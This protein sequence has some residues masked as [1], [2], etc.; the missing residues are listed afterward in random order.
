MSMMDGA[1]GAAGG[2][3]T[4]MRGGPQ[5]ITTE[6]GKLTWRQIAEYYGVPLVRIVER[7]E[8]LSS[9][10]KAQILERPNRTVRGG[11]QLTVPNVRDD[12]GQRRPR[13]NV[14]KAE[15]WIERANRPETADA[16]AE[17]EEEDGPGS[18][19]NDAPEA[20]E[21]SNPDAV[22]P[23]DP[24]P[25]R[26]ESVVAG[27]QA[28]FP[29][30]DS[31]GLTDT[32][33]GWIRNDG[34]TD[35][36]EVVSRLRDTDQ[37]RAQFVGIRRDDGTLR[38]NE[39]QY[40][41]TRTEYQR[42][43]QQYGGPDQSYED[44]SDFGVFF[45][46]DISVQELGQRFELYD[47]L[48]RGPSDIRAAFFVYAG[49][50]MSDDDLY[51][52]VV[53][54]TAREGLD[55]EYQARSSVQDLDYDTYIDRV[56]AVALDASQRSLENLASAGMDV[57]GMQ[58]ALQNVDQ[59]TARNF[60][61]VLN[62]GGTLDGG[63]LQMSELIAAFEYAAIGSAAA[64]AGLL[65]P[66]VDRLEEFRNAG[67]QRSQA[68][69]AYGDFAR[70]RTA[71]AAMVG[72]ARGTAFGQSEFENATFLSRPDDERT[73]R[74]AIAQEEARSGQTGNAAFERDQYGRVIQRGLADTRNY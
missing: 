32:I 59:A 5:T 18:T 74:A 71:L 27:L 1:V 35:P 44:P 60:V 73:L 70:D 47:S 61:D 28:S 53:D 2:T 57:T 55:A 68:I 50:P 25:I 7:V 67:I 63:A 37:Y 36:F 62:T 23:V 20:P 48:R 6:G 22:G 39:G 11:L 46:N 16:G 64:G 51:A 45:E 13:A 8:G 14:F 21:P 41:A 66:S 30:V 49:I 65:M 56:T 10:Q 19:V 26:A 24:D 42:L 29:W 9:R 72:R 17:E 31:L 12:R 4:G 33:L 3:A 40:L 15:K 54:P 38:M 58:Q 52:Y 34:I 43:L 69:S